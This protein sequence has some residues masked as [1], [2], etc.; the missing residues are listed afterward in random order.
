MNNLLSFDKN[1]KD[2]HGGRAE[3]HRREMEEV[4]LKV[5]NSEKE[6]LLEE[7]QEMIY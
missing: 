5:F 2:G 6:R 3:D 4:A 1:T 7:I